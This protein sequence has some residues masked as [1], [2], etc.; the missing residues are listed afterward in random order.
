[1]TVSKKGTRAVATERPGRMRAP[2]AWWHERFWIIDLLVAVVVF[3]YGLPILPV[4]SMN[5]MSLA[6]TGVISAGMCGA[7][8]FRRRHPL[9]VFTVLLLLAFVHVLLGTPV[10]AADFLL[11]LAVYNVATRA[12]WVVS[13]GCAV[14][15]VG[16]L[17][18]AVGPKVD[19]LYLNVGQLVQF[20][21]IIVVVWSWGRLVGTRRN[22]VTGLQ[23]R[24]RQLERERETQAYIAAAEERTRIAREIHDVVSHG[25]SAMV[26]MADAAASTVEAEP[27]RARSAM[28]TVRDTGRTA[29]AEMRRMLGV[30]RDDE[31]GS[32][33]P[34]PGINQLEQLVEEA[35][36]AG[37]PV[38][39]TMEGP[40]AP[41]SAGV[42]LAVY[43]IVQEALTN[44]RKHAGPEVEAVD[45]R[46]RYGDGELE[47]QVTDDGQG[48]AG[49][50][51]VVP[52][53]H[54]LVGMR[55]R[56]AAYDGTLHTGPRPSGGFKV[57]AVLPAE[58]M[59]SDDSRRAG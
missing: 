49:S 42:D 35:R 20:V 1:M 24:A 12:G 17:L 30:L 31:P 5:L 3:T 46:L 29:L 32:R 36:T 13:L 57:A 53:S 38:G 58:E 7:Y 15:L 40:P 33:A 37:L 59:D 26:V 28:L 41:V 2:G 43:R 51:D 27:E 21:L 11:L 14:T 50:A 45:V 25:L 18:L 48:T 10:I 22:Y 44:V 19:V 34:Q 54:G 52:R 6:L 9:R 8:L 47:V 23:E 16:W 55:E 4:Y 56:V 39:L